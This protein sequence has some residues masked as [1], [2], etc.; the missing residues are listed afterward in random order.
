[1]SLIGYWAS[2]LILD[3]VLAYVPILLIIALTFAFKPGFEGTWVLLLLYPPAVV[4]FTYVTSFMFTS[5]INAQIMTLF[6][7][8]VAGALCTIVVFVLQQVPVTMSIGDALRWTFT[9]IPSFCVS[10]GILFSASGNLITTSRA[11]NRT[12]DHVPIPRKIPD[13]IWAWYNLKG[14]AVILVAHFFIALFV[15]FLIEVEVQKL[16]SWMPKIRCRSRTTRERLG[17]VLV[18]D[19]DVI[20]EEKR[21]AGQGDA[22]ESSSQTGENLTQGAIDSNLQKNG[23]IDCIRVN[24]FSKEYEPLC[25]LPVK[26]VN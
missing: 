5:D 14:D 25:G 2:N 11:Q 1:M 7:H 4:P 13:D 3:I 15:L 21:V 8:F 26:A 9:I 17:P 19:D 12:K 24:N 18:K 10:Y 16:F 6:L 23:K 20:A 22:R